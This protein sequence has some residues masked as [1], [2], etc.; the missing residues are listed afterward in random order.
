MKRRL[1]LHVRLLSWWPLLLPAAVMAEDPFAFFLDEPLP[2]ATQESQDYQGWV[3]PS[4]IYISSDNQQFGRYNGLNDEILYFNAD[5]DY[6]SFDP[7]GADHYIGFT[8]RDLGLKTRQ[9]NVFWGQIS[10]YRFEFE[11]DQLY[12]FSGLAKS[13]FNGAGG[14]KLT[15]P[16]GW[17]SASVTGDMTGLAQSDDIALEQQRERLNLL[18][19]KRFDEMWSFETAF[20]NEEKNGLQ[21]LG[22]AFY[23]DA[24]NPHA[25]IL[26]QPVDYTTRELDLAAHMTAEKGNLE[27]RYLYSNFENNDTGLVWQNPYDAGYGVGVDYPAGYGQMGLAPDNQLHQLRASANYQLQDDLLAQAD[28]SYSVALQDEEFLPYTRNSTLALTEGLPRT[29]LDGE[30]N[31]TTLHASLR[32]LTNAQLTLQADYRYEDRDNQSP[33]DAYLYV[34]GDAGAQPASKYAVYNRP[35]SHTKNT[36][37]LEGLYRFANRSRMT[38]GYEYEE[39][40]RYNAAVETTKEDRF[41][42]G[43]RNGSVSGLGARFSV[44]YADR[45]GSTYQWDQSY[46]ALLDSELINETPAS[47]RYN[48][49]PLL[50]QY[51]LA[52]RQRLETK[53]NIALGG[54]GKWQHNLDTFWRD[55]DYDKTELGLLWEQHTNLTFSSSYLPSEAVTITGYYAL[56]YIEAE[57]RGRAFRGGLEKNAFVKVPPFPQASDPERD[58]TASSNDVSHALGVNARWQVQKDWLDLEMDYQFVD[59]TGEQSLYTYGAADLVG[60]GLPDNRSRQHHVTLQADHQVNRDLRLGLNYQY[61]RFKEA[62]WAVDGV[63]MDTIDKV[64]WTGAG[65]ANET[66]NAVAVT[67]HYNLP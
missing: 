44:A 66:V 34:R 25:S 65:S 15:L 12:Q 36:F 5:L 49:H 39:I 56:D 7:N 58:W 24:S 9:A 61:Y 21:T 13:P 41:S 30:V 18:F 6:L 17:V 57:Q 60:A 26:P 23:L 22:A 46:Y 40:A 59:T 4:F 45:G 14:A 2:R 42:F 63:G 11:Y 35:T 37:G 32:H 16:S 53:L 47:Q 54:S 48:N 27:L 19:R 43:L 28:A 8:A 51:Y 31:T 52:N 29:S 50:S 3:E 67:V 38:L 33:R 1:S 10:D 62:S 20:R 55:D 64:L